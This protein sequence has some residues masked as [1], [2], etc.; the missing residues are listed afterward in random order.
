MVVDS[1]RF[2][3]AGGAGCVYF[4]LVVGLGDKMGGDRRTGDREAEGVGVFG[5]E[6]LEEGGFSGA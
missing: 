6:A 5:E 3:G 2:A 4:L 1:G